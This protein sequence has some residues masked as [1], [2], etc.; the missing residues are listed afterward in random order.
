MTTAAPAVRQPLVPVALAAT[1][2]I[3]LDRLAVAPLP[4]W[5]GGVG[6]ALLGWAVARRQGGPCERLW[7][8][9][10][11]AA[12]AGAWHHVRQLPPAHDLG[13]LTREGPIPVRVRGVV[14]AGPDHHPA[15]DAALRSVANPAAAVLLVEARAVAAGADW[16]P[17]A[18]RLRA[19]V[20]GTPAGVA[21]GD[22]VEITGELH[23]V[24]PP[25]NPGEGDLRARW[26]DQ[27]VRAALHVKTA[28][29]VVPV[30]AGAWWAPAAAL[31]RVRGWAAD[32]VQSW[33]P[34]ERA[35]VARALL[36]GE[37]AA[38]APHQFE[39]YQRTGVYHALAVSGQHLVILT[40]G[41]G[42]ALRLL[43]RTPR[44]AALFQMAFV[45][46]YAALTGGQAPVLRAAVIVVALQLGRLLAR[47][48]QP[49]NSLAGAWLA[50]AALNPADLL[51]TGC[52]LSFLAT[53]TLGQVVRAWSAWRRADPDPL[54]RLED[55]FR[56]LWLKALR[57]LGDRLVEQGV[58]AAV[59]WLAVAPLVAARFHLVSPVAVLLGVPLNA[60]VDVA[61]Q[62]GFLG[63]VLAPLGLGP[64]G[65][66]VVDG[67]LAAADGLV[68]VADR[69]PG[70]WWYVPDVPEW[71][72]AGFY[73]GFL[74]T[75][76]WP[77]LRRRWRGMG[78]AGLAWLALGLAWPPPDPP[79]GLR[80]TFLAVGHGSCAVL[81]TPDGRTL[82]YDAG[83][84]AGPETAVWQ[85]APFL[86]SRGVS[87][88]DEVFLS[89][90]DLDHFNGLPALADRFPIARVSLTPSFAAKPI[91]GVR[92]ALE[93]LADRGIPLRRLTAG[94]TLQAGGVTLTVLHPPPAGP[95]GAENARSLTLLVAHAGRTLLLTGDLE[96]PGLGMVTAQPML[97]VDVLQ[98]PHHGSPVS[99]TEAFAR[100]C[101]PALA[102]VSEG[103]P[104][105]PRP[106][107][108]S[109]LGAVVW[110]TWQ[111]GAVTV[112]FG[113]EGVRAET[114]R[115]GR[116]WRGDGR[117]G[118]G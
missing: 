42:F 116:R 92:V 49:V 4:L 9:L 80:C 97:P 28:A 56:P 43:G 115:T 29:A 93:R 18:G 73:A 91:A 60:C 89:H 68:G 112:T 85:V 94:Q 38:L 114:Y 65:G 52:Q 36:L 98:A 70:G 46:L 11:A 72:L 7:L 3:L 67:A 23:A 51:T 87:R 57:W 50:V 113:R 79:A 63:L 66:V 39:A 25:G 26:A 48:P 30:A 96:P 32:R 35:A 77:P 108:Y 44:Q 58:A 59:V 20:G 111:E 37:T 83:S 17:A 31:D 54:D 117:D 41:L 2:G 88:I 118:E 10:A 71:W 74:V 78:L 101:R 62:F 104:R 82:L 53:L 102:V 1:A 33:L 106:D 109:P 19:H 107:P 76:L 16:G 95:P 81:E 99:N 45:S 34:R 90:A 13:R 55:Q 6:V 27:D 5:L 47:R 24:A 15:E 64:V 14:V 105:G 84:L 40:G 100:W 21:V 75:V 103:R 8:A 110:R 86:W 69:C 61:L 12:L 22:L